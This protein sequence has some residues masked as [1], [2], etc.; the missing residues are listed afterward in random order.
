MTSRFGGV[1]HGIA[2]TSTESD[3]IPIIVH[4]LRAPTV[5]DTDYNLGDI[6]IYDYPTGETVYTLTFLGGDSMSKGEL[7]TWSVMAAGTGSVIALAD[8][9]GTPAYPLSG[10]INVVGDGL[11]IF[12]S[13][14]VDNTITI[15][16]AGQPGEMFL[17]N[18]G[19]SIPDPGTGILKVYGGSNTGTRTG[20]TGPLFDIVYIDL[21]DDVSIAGSF[22]A[23]TGLTVTAGD[24]TFGAF[25][26]DEGILRTDATGKISTTYGAAAG[27]MLVTA[28]DGSLAWKQVLASGSVTVTTDPVT[29][30]LTIG[31]GGGSSGTTSFVTDAGTIVPD[32]TGKINVLGQNCIVTDGGTVNTIK[33]GVSEVAIPVGE[34]PVI[35]GMGVGTP[36]QWGSITADNGNTLVYAGGQIII[37][38]GGTSAGSGLTDMDVDDGTVHISIVPPLNMINLYGKTNQII[39]HAAATSEI[40]I[41][42]SPTLS[43][44]GTLT[45]PAMTTAGILTNNAS[46]L[47]SSSA[48]TDGQVIIGK[49]SG[50]PAWANLTAGAG[51][52]IANGANTIT[53]TN[54]ISGAGASVF[55]TNVGNANTSGGQIRILGGTNINT[56]G[57]TD[58]VTVNLN[59]N[60]ILPPTSGSTTTPP[61][62]G[63]FGIGSSSSSYGFPGDRFL[64]SFSGTAGTYRN[65]CFIGHGSGNMSATTANNITAV[66]ESAAAH[67]TTAT[68][69]TMVGA[70][71][72][73][74]ITSG[75]NNCLFGD[76]AGTLITTSDNNSA[77]GHW[78]SSRLIGADNCSFGANS[79]EIATSSNYTSCYGSN[80][81]KAIS[82][83]DNNC[84]FGYNSGLALNS[85]SYNCAFGSNVLQAATTSSYNV[86]I[87][88]QCLLG[89]TTS[90][91]GNVALG[92]GTLT[93]L[94]TGAYNFGV[95]AGTNYSGAESSNI[96]IH[97]AGVT[98]ESNTIK[99]GT[100]GTGVGQQS[101]CYIAGINGTTPIGYEKIVT[102]DS[103]DKLS[104]L[105]SVIAAGKVLMGTTTHP[106]WGTISSSGGSIAIDTSVPG[107]INLEQDSTYCFSAYLPSNLVNVIGDGTTEYTF[108]TTVSLTAEVNDG[109]PFSVGSGGGVAA[110]YTAPYN[111]F[112]SFC[113]SIQYGYTLPPPPPAPH[114]TDP[115]Y[116]KIYNVGG[117][118][119]RTYAFD[120]IL[121]TVAGTYLLNGQ[122]TVFCK[123]T[124]GQYAQFSVS[125]HVAS[126]NIVS[127][128]NGPGNTYFSG[129]LVGKL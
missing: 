41:Q 8:Q 45:I 79:L 29:G 4:E 39:T 14:A 77:F 57:G 76:S 91:G 38:G 20:Q 66:G 18:T 21:N 96:I 35:V 85:G 73:G 19:Q 60:V 111:G 62:Q 6:W 30:Q 75:S 15:T 10:I 101:K 63:M 83:G 98:G 81:G 117:G 26:G 49:T 100:T 42:I 2:P 95:L 113:V 106:V 86:A 33:V 36:S 124:V 37:R 104:P 107:I 32:G 11:N 74:S 67:I 128:G 1:P 122:Y 52:S 87:G 126:T 44:P 99:I 92:Y 55:V 89:L 78:S 129:F 51:I 127:I 108:G 114:Y 3:Q 23:G 94:K 43:L 82:T 121:P 5:Y 68:E 48:G 59:K 120:Y 7:A 80:S 84:L 50:I 125:S 72:G 28:A 70:N 31:G 105:A 25:A 69:C 123:M 71:A 40:E 47:I 118:L 109:T 16:Y 54:T 22:T 90:T 24:V 97:N 110:K 13:A 12:T 61:Y 103:N 88:Y 93:G 115:I 65:N 116:V 56:A 46:G 58:T 112:Y 27:D 34:A 102:I 53:I 64:H 9:A 119:Y 17:T